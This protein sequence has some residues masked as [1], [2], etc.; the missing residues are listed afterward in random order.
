MKRLALLI[1]LAISVSIAEAPVVAFLDLEAINCDTGIVRAI[2]ETFRTEVVSSY[3]F[4]MVERAQIGKVMEELAFQQSGIV[5]ANTAVELGRIVGADYVGIGSVNQISGS[6]SIAV[7]LVSVETSLVVGAAVEMA[8]S[9]NDLWDACSTIVK[10]IVEIELPER[11]IYVSKSETALMATTSDEYMVLG[12]N[13]V[14]IDDFS[15]LPSEITIEVGTKLWFVNNSYFENTATFDFFSSPILNAAYSDV[16][17]IKTTIDW[18][19]GSYSSP[20]YNPSDFQGR[21][22]SHVFNEAGDYYYYSAV[23]D[24]MAGEVHVK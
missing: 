8:R 12:V 4:A 17:R 2:S 16:P 13:M 22:W 6:Y 11:D 21:T 1:L 19:T 7:R 15:F 20:P 23:A 24:D 14:I 10:N 18:E 9:V 5:D 3:S